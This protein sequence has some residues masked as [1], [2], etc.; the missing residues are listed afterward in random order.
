MSRRHKVRRSGILRSIFRKQRITFLDYGYEGMLPLRLAR[1]LDSAP[2]LLVCR[3][4]DDDPDFYRAWNNDLGEYIG[5]VWYEE[6][7]PQLELLDEFRHGDTRY[8]IMRTTAAEDAWRSLWSRTSEDNAVA[9][10]IF[11]GECDLTELKSRILQSDPRCCFSPDEHAE[12][13]CEWFYGQSYGGGA[14]EHH[15]Y[16]HARN[17]GLVQK[18]REM[19]AALPP[20]SGVHITEDPDDPMW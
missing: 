17:P 10:S 12:N 3:F 4:E 5:P 6:W 13:L 14:D 20:D 18:L 19:I 8:T 16:F 1:E 2:P 15:A 11:S 7:L 9:D